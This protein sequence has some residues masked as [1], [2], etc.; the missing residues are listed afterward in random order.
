L[1]ELVPQA[2]VIALL[3]SSNNPLAAA[4]ANSARMQEAARAREMQLHIVKAS[5]EGEID[6]AFATLVELHAGALVV[7]TDLLFFGRREQLC[8]LA[9]CHSFPAI[10]Y[11]R[12][13]VDAGGLLSCGPSLATAYRQ[14]GIYAGKILGGARPSDLPVIHPT[15]FELVINSKTAK[16]LGLAVP[17][18]LLATADEVIE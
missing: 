9:A 5:S 14:A 12:E 2:R 15:K 10:C 18:T 11:R 17:P 13:F 8:A 1:S 16:T 4:P 6:A 3:V 7:N